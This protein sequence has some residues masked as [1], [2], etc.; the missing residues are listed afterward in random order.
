MRVVAAA[1][2]D[3]GVAQGALDELRRGHQLRPDDASLAPLGEGVSSGRTVLAGR[4]QESE[5]DSVRTTIA[6]FG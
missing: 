5:L 4:F 3:A 2:G 6:A 1:F